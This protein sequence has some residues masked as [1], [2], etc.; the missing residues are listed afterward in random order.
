MFNDLHFETT[1]LMQLKSF[2]TQLVLWSQ[3]VVTKPFLKAL[4]AS[5]WQHRQLLLCRLRTGCWRRSSLTCSTSWTCSNMAQNQEQC[6]TALGWRQKEKIQIPQYLFVVQRSKYRLGYRRV[7]RLV[8]S[9][10]G[11]QVL[12]NLKLHDRRHAL[13]WTIKTQRYADHF[14]FLPQTVTF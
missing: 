10:C 14:G 12:R 11:I 7:L 5:V 8:P 9:S 3:P 4:E 6:D 13:K 1:R 2:G